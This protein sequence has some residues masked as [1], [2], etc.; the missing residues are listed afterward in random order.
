[1]AQ[2]A[3]GLVHSSASKGIEF[4]TL[5]AFERRD[6]LKKE[7]SFRSWI[8]RVAT[9]TCLDH[10][11]KQKPWRVSVQVEVEEQCGKSDKHL[12]G[13]LEVTKDL[14]FSYDVQEHLSFCF[15]CV[16]RSLQPEEQAAVVLREVLG[17]SNQEAADLLEL[18]E[19]KLRHHLSAGRRQM[20]ATYED[21]CSLV[22][23]RGVCRQCA[24]FRS[25]TGTGPRQG[26]ALPVLQE[27]ADPWQ[28]RLEAVRAKHF[29]DGVSSRLH[30]LFFER[31]KALHP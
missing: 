3:S 7:G 19:S 18:S 4:P 28:A 27:A 22:N 2:C 30:D 16:G 11:R 6:S 21:L 14:A 8:F 29:L 9:T 17:F 25:T 23:K 13:F 12:Q 31:I 24:S 26:P 20:E 10:F 5:K 15:T 1:M